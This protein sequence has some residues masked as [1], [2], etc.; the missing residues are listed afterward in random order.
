MQ[1]IPMVYVKHKKAVRPEGSKTALFS[2]DPLEFATALKEAGIQTLLLHDLNLSTL[3]KS[4]NESVVS[5]IRKL[6]FTVHVTAT[7]RTLASV[8]FY[9]KK[10][11]HLCLLDAI[12][13][14]EPDFLSEVAKAHPKRIAVSI[15]VK[16][17]KLHI[18]GWAKPSH[19][20]AEEHAKEFRDEGIYAIFY[21]DVGS[22]GVISADSLLSTK[23]FCEGSLNRI[24]LTSEIEELH[25]IR[26]ILSLKLPR[27]EGLVVNKAFYQR[28]IDLKSGVDYITNILEDS[29][30]ETIA[31]E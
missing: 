31:E 20:T 26:K 22:D 15:D 24:F 12:A 27:L 6:G 25:D 21:S 18:P 29:A 4:E 8:E 2:E 10:G 9:L 1:L 5:D 16:E 23:R 17:K 3:A 13:Y 7:F 28:K 11:V 30:E 19:K 14:Q